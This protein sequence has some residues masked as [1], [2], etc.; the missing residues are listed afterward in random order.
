[1]TSF[2][3]AIFDLVIWV[4]GKHPLDSNILIFVLLGI[5][6]LALTR[7]KKDIVAFRMRGSFLRAFR[8]RS[9]L[10]L[11]ERYLLAAFGIATI[12]AGLF[13]LLEMP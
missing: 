11:A 12:Y 9:A 5:F 13:L 6:P 8:D 2:L 3:L 10:D 7:I 1:M 4:V